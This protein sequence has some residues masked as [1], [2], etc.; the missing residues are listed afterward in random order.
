MCVV[1]ILLLA[2][3]LISSIVSAKLGDLISE[4]DPTGYCLYCLLKIPA[5]Y[6]L[7]L[8]DVILSIW[9]ISAY[10]SRILSLFGPGWYRS[11]GGLFGLVMK[12]VT[13]DTRWAQRNY[14]EVIIEWIRKRKLD[15]ICHLISGASALFLIAYLEMKE[16]FWWEVSWLIAYGV[17]GLTLVISN[18]IVV[19]IAKEMTFGQLVP[20]VLIILPFFAFLE[21]FDGKERS[22]GNIPPT[23]S[24]ASESQHS[25]MERQEPSVPAVSEDSIQRQPE[26]GKAAVESVSEHPQNAALPFPAAQEPAAFQLPQNAQPIALRDANQ[27]GNVSGKEEEEAGLGHSKNVTESRSKS[28]TLR[29]GLEKIKDAVHFDNDELYNIRA[30]RRYAF[31]TVFIYTGFMFEFASLLGLNFGPGSALGLYFSSLLFIPEIL[32]RS[33]QLGDII[34]ALLKKYRTNGPEHHL[35][36]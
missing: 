12:H 23:S 8:T 20:L 18:W 3:N 27:Q 22:I 4:A 30:F 16:S 31:F 15:N 9:I 28:A 7:D 6:F 13:G 29:A 2:S 1:G 14:Q 36:V 35:N 17:Y 33:L 5:Q 25:Q 34:N 10:I 11:K 21:A 19:P 24:T 32:C 26:G